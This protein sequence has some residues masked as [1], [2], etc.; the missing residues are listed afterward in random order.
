MAA[1]QSQF[2]SQSQ[3]F[4]PKMID[5]GLFY[6]EPTTG[7]QDPPQFCGCLGSIFHMVQ[8]IDHDD[9]VKKVACKG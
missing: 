1:H 8:G 4:D 2:F 6:D 3:Q 7:F 9:G 5:I